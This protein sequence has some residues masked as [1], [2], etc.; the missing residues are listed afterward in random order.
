[1]L[2][3]ASRCAFGIC[4][5][6]MTG[7]GTQRIITSIK[8]AAIPLT[9]KNWETSIH[10]PSALGSVY[11]SQKWENGRQ[12]TDMVVITATKYPTMIDMET[13]NDQRMFKMRR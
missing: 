9:R 2:I 5:L 11:C 13:Y 1:M 4:N 10:T 6:Q 8:T 12:A 7:A 3:T